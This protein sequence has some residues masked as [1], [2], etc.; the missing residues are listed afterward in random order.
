MG[1]RPT[2]PGIDPLSRFPVQLPPPP[3]A[4]R[5]NAPVYVFARGG[6]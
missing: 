2:R 6:A 5:E 3:G 4:Y 1:K